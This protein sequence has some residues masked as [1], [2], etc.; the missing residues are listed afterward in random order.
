MKTIAKNAI[1]KMVEAMNENSIHNYYIDQIRK[2]T[3]DDQKV[4]WSFSVF[5]VR[6]KELESS[7]VGVQMTYSELLSDPDEITA[8]AKAMSV[9]SYISVDVVGTKPDDYEEMKR[10]QWG[11]PHIRLY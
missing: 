9:G 11:K 5:Q 3:G 4:D 1:F 6:Y 2:V 10:S 8:A 7:G